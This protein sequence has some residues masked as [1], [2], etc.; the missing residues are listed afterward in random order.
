VVQAVIEQDELHTGLHTTTLH[1]GLHTGLAFGVKTCLGAHTVVVALDRAQV[2]IP[3]VRVPVH[4][5][6][7]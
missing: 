1:T 5:P 6:V 3:R 2:D 7:A 4:E